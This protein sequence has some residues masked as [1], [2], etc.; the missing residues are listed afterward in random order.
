MSTRPEGL[1][2]MRVVMP[3]YIDGDTVYYRPPIWCVICTEN[4]PAEYVV[5]GF[6]VCREHKEQSP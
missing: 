1:D 6:S 2:L 3:G 5:S 4:K